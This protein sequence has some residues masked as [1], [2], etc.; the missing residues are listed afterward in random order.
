[1]SAQAE[2]MTATTT[3]QHLEHPA[4]APVF[5]TF[6]KATQQEKLSQGVI[7]EIK[8]GLYVSHKVDDQ[9]NV[10][11]FAQ[12]RMDILKSETWDDIK[13]SFDRT[14]S[15]LATSL[16]EIFESKVGFTQATPEQLN[17]FF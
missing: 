11:F 17:T 3:T 10:I 12:E 4:L 13:A 2:T 9:D 6:R 1:M 5:T 7:R 15:C 16:K 14:T 8:P